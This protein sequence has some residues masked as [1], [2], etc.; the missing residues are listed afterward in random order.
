MCSDTNYHTSECVHAEVMLAEILC[1]KMHL[2]LKLHASSDTSLSITWLMFLHIKYNDVFCNVI[3]WKLFTSLKSVRKEL[4][5]S[6]LQRC[7]ILC[8]ISLCRM[9]VTAS[10]LTRSN[11][12][13]LELKSPNTI[14]KV[15]YIPVLSTSATKKSHWYI[16]SWKQPYYSDYFWSAYHRICLFS[17]Y[18]E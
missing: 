1:W 2:N 6:P 18:V 14:M 7:S 5:Y 15:L 8:S 17:V 3:E 4:S 16:W 10:E 13:S 11:S 12:C 9:L